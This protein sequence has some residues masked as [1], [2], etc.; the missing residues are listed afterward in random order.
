MKRFERAV[1]GLQKRGLLMISGPAP[2]RKSWTVRWEKGRIEI[3]IGSDRPD[4]SRTE[5]GPIMFPD[6]VWAGKVRKKLRM[7][8]CFR[9]DQKRPLYNVVV[10]SGRERTMNSGFDDRHWQQI[11]S[12]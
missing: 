10:P 12:R 11:T 4:K 9:D 2:N 7:G 6:S 5:S 3:R 1:D 8:S